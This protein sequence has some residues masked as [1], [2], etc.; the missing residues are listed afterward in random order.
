MG[1]GKTVIILTAIMNLLKRKKIKAALVVAPLRVCYNVWPNEI[2]KWDH[3]KHLR[4]GILHGRDKADVLRQKLDIYIINYEGLAWLFDQ[5]KKTPTERVNFDM[6][7]FD[8]STAIKSNTTQRFKKLKLMMKMFKRRVI[9]TGTPAPN[10]LLDLW[11]QYYLLDDGERLGTSKYWFQSEYFWQA[12]YQGY[13]FQALPYASEDI[14]KKVSDITVRLKAEDYLDMPKLIDN[15]ITWKM[16]PKI[17]ATY[18]TLEDDFIVGIND[19][20]IVAQ[21]AAVLSAKLRQYVSGFVYDEE[22]RPLE[23]H[24]EKLDALAEIREGNAGENLLVAIQFRHEYELIN[25]KFPNVP[26]IYG[27]MSQKVTKSIIKKWNHGKIPMLVVHPASIAH[28]VNLQ[29]GGRMLV[30]YGIPWSYE[31]Y[32]Q[33]I[34]RL[35]RQGQ[36]KPVINSYIVA[37]DSIE[38]RVVEALQRKEDTE[39]TFLKTLIGGL[40]FEKQETRQAA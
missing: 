36:T 17:R 8:E 31:H 29:E 12:D 34:G 25:R 21:N 15:P 7:V 6:I 38:E 20:I 14:S 10:S 2:E 33:L 4:Y 32:H 26:V 27:N 28:G 18:K 35:H 16:T 3:T 19:G 39:K 30:W 11:S 9:L 22:R 37:H 5:I 13:D 1:L 40:K 24:H 23:A